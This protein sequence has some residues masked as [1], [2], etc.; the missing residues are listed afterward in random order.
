MVRALFVRRMVGWPDGVRVISI[1]V[2]RMPRA[3]P[4]PRAFAQA[5]FA[6]KRAA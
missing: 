2:K 3:M 6:A 1:S 5:S 4:V